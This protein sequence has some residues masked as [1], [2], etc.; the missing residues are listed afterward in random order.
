MKEKIRQFFCGLAGHRRAMASINRGNAPGG[1]HVYCADCKKT[2][3][4]CFSNGL[5]EKDMD[6]LLRKI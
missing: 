6:F 2:I 4:L 5:P 3:S 1:L